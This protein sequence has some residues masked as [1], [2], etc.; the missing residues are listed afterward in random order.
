MILTWQKV[1][2]VLPLQ[3]GVWFWSPH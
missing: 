1:P 3:Y 2:T